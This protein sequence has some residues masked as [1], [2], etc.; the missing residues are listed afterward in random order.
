MVLS[1]SPEP[2]AMAG[3]PYLRVGILLCPGFTLTPVASFVD[4]LRLAADRGDRSRQVY[5]AWEFIAAAAPPLRASCG[6]EVVPTGALDLE[7][8]DCLVVCGGLIREL[9]GVLPKVRAFLRAA[10]QRRIPIVALCTGSF[11]LAESGLLDGGRAAMHFAVVEEFLRR[12][13]KCQAIA[14]VNFIIDGDIITCAGSIV[15]IEVAA[16]LIARYGDP[17]R[18]RK[19]LSYLLFKPEEAPS[20][21]RTKPWGPALSRASQLTVDAVQYMEFRLDAPCSVSE[22]A[23]ALNTTRTR[24][25]RAFATDLQTAPAAFWRAMRLFA[26]RELLASRRRTISEIAYDVGF[27]DTAH[28][29]RTFR[30]HEGVT[31]QQYRQALREGAGRSAPVDA[32]LGAGARPASASAVA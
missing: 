7:R 22:L 6:L 15:A 9:P 14:D 23:T 17:S 13:P 19:A 3:L 25:N 11:V 27:C 5:F 21:A 10:A 29:C 4:A 18:A 8:Y 28:F 30:T 1:L 26:A 16:H 12:F 24:L 2:G 20:G 32:G 31:P